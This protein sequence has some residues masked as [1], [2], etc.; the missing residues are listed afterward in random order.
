MAWRRLVTRKDSIIRFWCIAQLECGKGYAEA[1]GDQSLTKIAFSS[2]TSYHDGSQH[3]RVEE[4][5]GLTYQLVKASQKDPALFAR[6]GEY[7]EKLGIRWLR[8]LEKVGKTN[9]KVQSNSAVA[10]MVD[11]FA[12][13]YTDYAPIL[14]VP[15]VV[16]KRYEEEYPKLLDRIRAALQEKANSLLQ[17][18]SGLLRA[19]NQIGVVTVC[20]D[21]AHLRDTLRQVLE[22][23]SRRTMAEEKADAILGVAAQIEG[24]SCAKIFD[25]EKPPSP[26]EIRS[27]DKEIFDS[28]VALWEKYRWLKH[29]GYPPYYSASTLEDLIGEVRETVRKRPTEQLVKREE[30]RDRILQAQEVVYN[31]PVLNERE[32]A[33]LQ[34][35]NYYAFL[36]T[37]RME[38]LI[39][40]QFLSIPLFREAER[41]MQ[42]ILDKDEIFLLTP[43]EISSYL[44]TEVLSCDLKAR[45][46]GWALRATGFPRRTEIWD[47]DRLADFEND[48]FSVIAWN[49]NGRGPHSPTTDFV[50]GKAANLYKL[51]E[52]DYD[53]P[54]F[55]VV[56]SEAFRRTVV[57]STIYQNIQRLLEGLSPGDKLEDVFSKLRAL[58]QKIDFPEGIRHA[59]ENQVQSLGLKEVA[60]RSSATLEDSAEYSW[61]GRFQSILPV[62]IDK[63]PEAI[64]EV[65]ASLFSPQALAYTLNAKLNLLDA[66]MAVIIQEV[67]DPDI[68][69]VM[70]SCLS[71]AQKDVVEIEAIYGLGEPL[72][73]GEMTPDRYLVDAGQEE[74]QVKRSVSGQGRMLSLKGWVDVPESLRGRSKLPDKLIVQLARLGKELES[75]F[76]SPQDVEFAVK[77]DKII[78]LQ[79]RPQTGLSLQYA[80]SEPSETV[81]KESRLVATGLRGK[82]AKKVRAKA[83]VL[84]N[85]EEGSRFEDGNVLVVNA[86]T[87]SWDP[88][89][90]RASA[91]VTNEGGSTCHAI[92][93]A[94]ERGFPAVVGTRDSTERIKDGDMVLVDTESDT[95]EGKVY[96]IR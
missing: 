1:T 5:K 73:S 4:L 71:L 85:L 69:G 8:F 65:W 72:V 55:F 58:L 39:K 84:R 49:E 30:E 83:Q 57:S 21:E 37:Y 93:V 70:N 66:K 94:N 92:R 46:K 59:I 79:T 26:E 40:A 33:L 18:N 24:R 62:G 44:R 42:D 12:R 36:R 41:C 28:I 60:V 20:E 25:A 22:Y 63:F 34:D 2:H 67:L 38:I 80:T 81:L 95:F 29:W 23:T 90:F 64:K 91:I 89:A 45:R 17:G 53:T 11:E 56:T 19:L 47:G 9:L 61:A 86:A 14:Y 52:Y 16:E 32:K 74:Y 88:I 48:F 35:I 51:L 43:P 75:S 31:M 78:I 6:I 50:G 13:Y 15:F 3:I 77:D 54:K 96:V 87:P 7:Y 76:G 82:V 68:A 10:D 27:S